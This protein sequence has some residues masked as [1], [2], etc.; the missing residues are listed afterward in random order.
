MKD[1]WVYMLLCA[2]GSY[3]IGVTNDVDRRLSDHQNGTIAGCYTHTRR[4]VDLVFSD[5]FHEIDDAIAWEKRIKRWTRAKKAALARGDWDEV[6][7]LSN[8]KPEGLRQA[9]ARRSTSSR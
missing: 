9:Q 2:D 4:P 1:Y 6:K 7:R 8:A 3:Y 5:V